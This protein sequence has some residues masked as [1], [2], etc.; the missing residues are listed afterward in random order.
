ME[1]NDA[2]VAYSLNS[3]AARGRMTMMKA[4]RYVTALLL[5]AGVCAATPA[6]AGQLYGYGGYPGGGVRDLERR[7]YD[8]G[9]REGLEQGRNDARRGRDFSYSRHDQYRDADQG[10][11]RS[12]GDRE[13]YRRS[14]RQGFQ[15]GYT[16]AYN[17]NA[18]GGYR[19]DQRGVYPSEY[20]N[21]PNAYPN[22]PQNRGG[23]GSP[24]AQNGYRDGL[25]AGRDDARDRDR[26]DP[27]RAKRYREGDHDYDRRYGSR[28]E[29]KR[30]YRAAFEQGYR[31]GY[32]RAR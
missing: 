29:Y 2:R 31:E 24:A 26:F 27:A 13:F 17:R 30:E 1:F 23:Y 15:T 21:Y 10:Y 5:A 9:Y 22:Y 18:R 3:L 25:E 8:I 28:D 19:G 20:P 4:H 6:C 14:Y 11:R 12:E 7:G 32:G 16:E